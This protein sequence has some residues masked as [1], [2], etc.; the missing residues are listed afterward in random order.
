MSSFYTKKYDFNCDAFGVIQY[1][2]KDKYS[3]IMQIVEEMV[4]G[5]G[6]SHDAIGLSKDG[7]LIRERMCSTGIRVGIGLPHG[8]TNAVRQLHIGCFSIRDDIDFETSDGKPV[9]FVSCMVIPADTKS[10][11]CVV[12]RLTQI[13]LDADFLPNVVKAKTPEELK[14]VVV[15]ATKR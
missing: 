14:L 12:A 13:A 9:F 1:Y 2:A 10:H 5:K 4:E 8:Q 3:L 6:Y 15:D 7:V 11:V